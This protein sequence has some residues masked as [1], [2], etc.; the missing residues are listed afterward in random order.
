MP[1]SAAWIVASALDW[2][3]AAVVV[4]SAAFRQGAE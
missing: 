2:K 1:G 3:R 4:I